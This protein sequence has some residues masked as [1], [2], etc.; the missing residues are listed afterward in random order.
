MQVELNAL[1]GNSDSTFSIPRGQWES[2][3]DIK[4]ILTT[5][6]E[7]GNYSSRYTD[8]DGGLVRTVLGQWEI[9]G[10]SLYLTEEN[11]TTAY[12]FNW[13]DG[14]GTFKAFLDW[15]GDGLSDDLY[16]GIQTKR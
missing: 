7:D 1:G 13:K 5:Y 12:F 15:D 16:T 6:L 9:K 2:T 8:L 3:L 14:Q 4:P 11:N 10:D